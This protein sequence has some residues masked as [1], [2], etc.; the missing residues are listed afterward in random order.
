MQ[1]RNQLQSK[2]A[3]MD[4]KDGKLI[5]GKRDAKHHNAKPWTAQ[6]DKGSNLVIATDMRLDKQGRLSQ[7]SCAK[8]SM[9]FGAITC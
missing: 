5:A 8:L 7:A 1:Q 6:I 3:F 9:D 2:L 4:P